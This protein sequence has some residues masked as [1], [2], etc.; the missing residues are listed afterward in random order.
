MMHNNS[1]SHNAIRELRQ[2]CMT[3]G[4]ILLGTI[5]TIT[6]TIEFGYQD[7]YPPDIHPPDIHPL[8]FT[9]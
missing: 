3:I 8:P 2:S 9:P 4:V 6:I 5:I 1:F 7:T